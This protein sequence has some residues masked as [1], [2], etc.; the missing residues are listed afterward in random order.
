V[1]G[2]Y[3]RP[4]PPAQIVTA[5]ASGAVDV[6]VVWGPLAGFFAAQSRTALIWRPVAPAVD[7][8]FLPFAFDISMGVRRDDEQLHGELDQFISGHRAAITAL[9]GRFHVPQ[10]AVDGSLLKTPATQAPRGGR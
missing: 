5:V 4:N 7:P 9:L 3:A 6:A 1:L 10:F 8:P 2:D